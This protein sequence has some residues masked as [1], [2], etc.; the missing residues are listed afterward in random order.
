MFFYIIEDGFC[1]SIDENND[2]IT[3]GP[4]NC[5][6]ELE[7]LYDENRAVNVKA[8]S[9]CLIWKLEKP[10][11]L[12]IIKKGFNKI[13]NSSYEILKQVS[14]LQ[15]IDD[16]DLLNISK[17]LVEIEY[18]A[19]E[20]VLTKGETAEAFY[21]IKE[22][23]CEYCDIGNNKKSL[24]LKPHYFFG[25][26]SILNNEPKVATVNTVSYTKLLALEKTK[27]LELLGDLKQNFIDSYPRLV[28]Q[29]LPELNHC[30]ISDK[31]LIIKNMFTK[32]YHKDEIICKQGLKAEAFYIVKSGKLLCKRQKLWVSVD[33]LEPS[34]ISSG[35]YFN[36]T[37]FTC[38]EMK[39]NIINFNSIATYQALEDSELYVFTEHTYLNVTTV[40][41]S[42]SRKQAE[43][44]LLY[45]IIGFRRR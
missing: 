11:F 19:H 2:K 37:I 25:E 29:S 18:E 10:I 27:F 1:E 41:I 17:E 14:I 3:Y 28:I 38:P 26:R 5:F 20:R 31:D 16:E 23:Y 13:F 22:G 12:Y 43:V 4:C 39:Y 36:D 42:S 40:R 15:T 34:I 33:A 30:L 24:F 21:I 32:V 35:D 9:T 45:Y 44:L 8:K 7:L 6:G